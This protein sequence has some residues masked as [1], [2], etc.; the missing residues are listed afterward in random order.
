MIR[1]SLDH[2]EDLAVR[3]LLASRVG[4]HNAHSVARALVAAEAD[5]LASHGLL[6]LPMYADQSL[7]GKVNGFAEPLVERTAAA[8]LRIDAREGFAFPAI[9]LAIEEGARITAESGVAA[10]GIH[11]SHHAGAVGHHVEAAAR[12][13]L[14]ALAFANSRAAIAPWGGNAPLF[15]TN[16]IAFAAPRRKAPPLLI[17]LSVSKVARGRIMMAQKKG[18]AIPEGWA[19]DTEGSPTT[20]ATDAMAGTMVP[21]GE[22]K[23]AALGLMVE[24]LAAGLTGATFGHQTSSMFEAEGAPPHLGQLFLFLSP[25][26]LGGA[27]FIDRLEPLLS[28]VLAQPG[29]RL[30]GQRRLDARA[31]A[32]TRGIDIP[33]SLHADLQR[34]SSPLPIA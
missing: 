13:G 6:R 21:I 22:A 12:R 8:T 28:A 15:G 31:A 4:E 34:R 23:G 32:A 27:G 18:E 26:R 24:I 19:L 7:S 29:T 9:T 25:E 1:L 3:V 17:D 30:P 2:A 14:V 16:P 20:D 33:H 11:N 5:G 10:V